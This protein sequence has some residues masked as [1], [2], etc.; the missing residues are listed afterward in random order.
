MY[1]LEDVVYEQLLAIDVRRYF[2]CKKTA[3]TSFLG[4]R[5]STLNCSNHSDAKKKE[6]QLFVECAL[7]F[8]LD[9]VDEYK[10]QHL[11]MNYYA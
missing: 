4:T 5:L 6:D 3:Y 10:T 9:K 7:L 11:Q 1:I 8:L 2:L